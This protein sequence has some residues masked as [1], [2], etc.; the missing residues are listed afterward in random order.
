MNF[1]Q[2]LPPNDEDEDTFED[3]YENDFAARRKLEEYAEQ[4]EEFV[5]PK[6]RYEWLSPRKYH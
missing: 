1:G 4:K 6:S 5:Q 2:F 3:S